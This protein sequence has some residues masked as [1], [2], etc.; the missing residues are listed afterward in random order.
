MAPPTKITINEGFEARDDHT[1]VECRTEPI[2]HVFDARALGQGPAQA[3]RDAIAAGIR[4]IASKTQDGKRQLFNRTGH[5]AEAMRA[6]P[7]TGDDWNILR[8]D[9][10]LRDPTLLERLRELVPA[11]RDPLQVREVRDAIAN[12]LRSV[13]RRRR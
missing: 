13:V 5:L 10:R 1:S 3:I 8:P 11:L 2:D 7:G 4:A 6:E 9:D 12:T